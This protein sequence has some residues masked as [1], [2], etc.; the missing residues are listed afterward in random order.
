M[1]SCT[2]GGQVGTVKTNAVPPWVSMLSRTCAKNCA[3]VLVDGST[4]TLLTTEVAPAARSRRQSAT[5]ILEDEPGSR[6]KSRSQP[7]EAPFALMN[8][9]PVPTAE[10][11]LYP[12]GGPG[13]VTGRFCSRPFDPVAYSRYKYGS[14][15]AADAFAQALGE[16]F[17][18]RCPAVV[19]TPRLLMTS[20]PYTYVPT[21]A[22]TLARRLQPVLNTVRARHG[23][24]PVPLIQ[25]ERVSPGAGDYG[26]LSASDRDRR[27]AARTLSFRR[28]RSDQLR[29]AHLLVIDD[30]RVT[31]AHQRSLT[32]AS[33]RLPLAART[34]LY[35]A[36]FRSPAPGCSDPTLFDPTQ[37]D[38]T[39]EDALNH[40][41]VTTLDDL[42]AIVAAD[43]F[44]W[45][46]RVCK[47]VLSPARRG[48]LSRFLGGMP[49]WF[50]RD[51]DRNARRDGYSGM[52][53]YAPSHA[54]VRADLGRRRRR[55]VPA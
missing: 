43:D 19:G 18:G 9:T 39:Q 7:D 6:A 2:S 33:E 31:G 23:V 22:T 4:H 48:G 51:L 37:F 11:A 5:R 14:I 50:V 25:V 15:A 41:A 28:F 24:P 10:F 26:T 45:N 13:P 20:S 36:A 29:D 21:A 54:I 17:A 8:V 53:C 34:F 49:D 38:P 44:A 46:V 47:F 40:A 3:W 12:L 1:L 55:A 16:A 52:A 32:Q 27:M 42:A 35:I 30:L